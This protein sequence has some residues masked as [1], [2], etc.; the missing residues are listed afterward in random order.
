M[1]DKEIKE[2]TAGKVPMHMPGH[3]R[4]M[5]PVEGLPYEIDITEIEGA[6]DLHDARGML[7]ASMKRASALWGSKRTWYLVGGSTCGILAGIRAAIPFGSEVIAARNCHRSVYHAL[8]LGGYRVHWIYPPA[9]PDYGFCLSVPPEE[10]GRALRRFPDA[11]GVV[12]TSPT[13]EGVLSDVRAIAARCHR[14]GIPLI[15]DEAHG[16]HLGLFEEGGF[17]PGAVSRGADLVVQSAHKTLPALTQTGLLHIGPR[18]RGQEVERQLGIFETS[19]PSYPLMASL[20]GCVDLL[21]ERGPELFEAWGARLDHFDQKTAGLARIEIFGRGASG[22][23]GRHPDM[24]AFDRSKILIGFHGLHLTGEKA[25][26]ILR[27]RYGIETE[28]AG[29]EYVLA[30]TGCGDTDENLEILAAALCEMDREYSE[31]EERPSG[32]A[33][34]RPGTKARP[35]GEK[36][37]AAYAAYPKARTAMR[38]FDAVNEPWESVPVMS[39]VGRISAEYLY[40]YPPGIPF[41]APGEYIL[42]EHMA[43][44]DA[45]KKRGVRVH[46]SRGGRDGFIACVRE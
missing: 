35:E 25:A 15:V 30:M 18:I 32:R 37:R 43:F 11:A 28:M 23:E 22:Q 29:P 31:A 24:Y 16:A 1:L 44:L 40:L 7:A 39:C 36:P 3:K 33:A 19:S 46:H 34:G 10:I 20:D 38:S 41:L 9:D 12:I 2:L 14:A 45:Q 8:E 6:D 13:Y 42:E 17:A 21:T 26:G 5:A 27:E 4:A